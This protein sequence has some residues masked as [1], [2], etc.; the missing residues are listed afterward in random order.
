MRE[1]E[2]GK[3]VSEEK[4]P[5]TL[6]EARF[7]LNTYWGRSM[8][9]AEANDSRYCF[10]TNYQVEQYYQ[11]YKD[12]QAREQAALEQTGSSKV[13]LTKAQIEEL[14]HAE[15]VTKGAIHPDTGKPI[16]MFMRI[17]FFL[18][19]NMVIVAGMLLA[20]PTI[21]NTLLWQTINQTYNAIL[22][23]GNA[24]KSSPCTN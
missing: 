14:R 17:T 21:F 5:F 1:T 22:N 10:L 8:A 18:P 3:T 9:L 12:Q 19:A 11:I 23:F 16:P 4:I 24:N 6:K 13:L 20:K 7:N 15:N 2:S